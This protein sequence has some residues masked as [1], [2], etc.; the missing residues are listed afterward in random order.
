MLESIGFLGFPYREYNFKYLS[1]SIFVNIV[2]R[3]DVFLNKCEFHLTRRFLY[4]RILAG[5]YVEHFPDDF[6]ELDPWKVDTEEKIWKLVNSFFKILELSDASVDNTQIDEFESL[7][8]VLNNV[9]Y[10][11]YGGNSNREVGS[12]SYT[13]KCD[14]L[15]FEN[16]LY[17]FLPHTRR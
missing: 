2:P 16:G 8:D 10:S 15:H 6:A 5:Y 7:E 13:P 14:V 12:H 11:D 4:K 3:V 1:N 9:R 17:F